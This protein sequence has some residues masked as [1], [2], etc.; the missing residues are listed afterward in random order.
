M[1]FSIKKL[2]I[3]FLIACLLA[4]LPAGTI[5]AQGGIAIDGV[6][7]DWAGMTG[8]VDPGGA[9]D[10]TDPASADITEYRI[11][12]D[13]SGV[14]LLMVWDDT[15]FQQDSGAGIT[16]RGADGVYYRIYAIATGNPGTVPQSGIQVY[17]ST[18]P[19]F[20]P[21]TTSQVCTG[22]G[23]SGLTVGSAATWVDPFA[24]HPA[25]N[26]LGTNCSTL[27]TAG[28]FGLPWSL[29]GGAPAPG[30]TVFFQYGSYPN[31]PGAALKDN[32]GSNGITVRNNNGVFSS[33]ISTP[34]AVTLSSLQA[35]A[36][37]SDPAVIAGSLVLGVFLAA[38]LYERKLQV[39]FE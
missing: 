13:A 39:K 35:T 19:A 10:E 28:E 29:V 20:P 4:L 36:A 22:A 24:G 12:A 38:L 11:Y 16:M 6:F 31:G 30:E 2:Q 14:Y 18:D 3:I 32:T 8:M 17:Q 27:D 21:E 34:T 15:Q 37:G 33:Y 25:G 7:T 9:D 26:C 5:F 23:C 1:K